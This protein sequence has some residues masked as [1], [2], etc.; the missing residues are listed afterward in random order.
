MGV[1]KPRVE[2]DATRP[3][4]SMPIVERVHVRVS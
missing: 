4:P 3:P 2:G 1:L